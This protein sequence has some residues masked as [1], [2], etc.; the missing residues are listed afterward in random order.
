MS[1][2]EVLIQTLSKIEF[3]LTECHDFARNG[4]L[5]D[6]DQGLITYRD[7]STDKVCQEQCL[8]LDNCKSFVYEKESKICYSY[9]QS[10]ADLV[11]GCTIVSGPKNPDMASCSPNNPCN[12]SKL[13]LSSSSML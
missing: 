2:P 1:K 4:C 11:L 10:L 6:Q 5:E 9:K 13:K 3:I 8:F 7:V 12:V